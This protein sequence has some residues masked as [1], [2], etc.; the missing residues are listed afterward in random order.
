M[1]RVWIGL[2]E[3]KGGFDDIFLLMFWCGE[4]ERERED[5]VCVRACYGRMH[6][7][8]VSWLPFLYIYCCCLLVKRRMIWE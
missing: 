5:W 7:W 2:D 4:R 6:V 8:G 1:R 3:W